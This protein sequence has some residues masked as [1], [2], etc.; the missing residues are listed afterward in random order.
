MSNMSYVINSKESF[1]TFLRTIV[2]DKA[3]ASF[4]VSISS[5]IEYKQTRSAEDW[6]RFIALLPDLKGLVMVPP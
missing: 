4:M 1:L 6:M 3:F 2:V 5:K